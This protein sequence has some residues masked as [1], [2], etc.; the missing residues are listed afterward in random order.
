MEEVSQPNKLNNNSETLDGGGRNKRMGQD[1]LELLP[2]S[3]I[4]E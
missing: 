4:P 2:A 1:V 3:L